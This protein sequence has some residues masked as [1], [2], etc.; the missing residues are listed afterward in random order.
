[1][2]LTVIY[3][4]TVDYNLNLL[5]SGGMNP[6]NLPMIKTNG[7]CSPLYPHNRVRVNTIF[8]AVVAAGKK[9]A[10]ADKHPTYDIVRG[11]SSTGLTTGYFP[12]I[13]NAD[14]PTDNVDKCIV[15]DTLHLNAFLGWI[16][17][18]DPANAEGSLKGDVPA[19][20][21]GNFQSGKFCCE[22]F[23]GST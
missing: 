2:T 12:E 13:N 22:S 18:K 19:L 10:Y 3:D 1:L 11:P 15:Y 21:G 17:G 9:T 16:D 23:H 5:F 20:F 7:K 8:E 6:A 4:E 14:G